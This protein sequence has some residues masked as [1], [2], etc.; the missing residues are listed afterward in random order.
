[1]DFGGNL[2]KAL[3]NNSYTNDKT[4]GSPENVIQ[5]QWSHILETAPTHDT[6]YN[7]KNGFV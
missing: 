4:C 7:G 2:T 3:S 1:M 5:R 6:E